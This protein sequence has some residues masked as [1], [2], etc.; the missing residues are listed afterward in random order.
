MNENNQEIFSQ[1]VLRDMNDAVLVLD[2]QGRVLYIN[3]PASD[4]LEIDLNYTPGQTRFFM[5]FGEDYNDVFYECIMDALYRK[6]ES[7][8]QH[9]HYKAPS[10]KTYMFR[11]SSAYLVDKSGGVVLTLADESET[12]MLRLRVQESSRTFSTF[13]FAFCIWIIFYAS[14][15][16]YGKPFATAQM[17]RGVEVL[18]LVMFVYIARYTGL[19]R[20]DLGIAPENLWKTVRMGVLFSIGGAAFLFALKAAARFFSPNSFGPNDP[21]WD[22]RTFGIPQLIYIFTAGIQE[23]LAR[24]V[25]QSN[26]KRIIDGKFAA[27]YSILLSSMIFAGLHIHLGFLFMIGA[28]ILASLEGIIYEKERSLYSV[29]IFHWVFGVTGTMLHLIDH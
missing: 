21:F 13:L 7:H 8:V 20:R 5:D 4:M 18:G 12:E 24:S 11:M 1:Q 14:W 22:I 9:V 25:M 23:F 17:T 19:T 28:I 6:E 29:W 10:G 2:R 15:E 27:A 3:Q 26:L 16:F